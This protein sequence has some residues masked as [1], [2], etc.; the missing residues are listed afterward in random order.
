MIRL[1]LVRHGT[2]ELNKTGV[3]YGSTDC[4]LSEE[5][6][7]ESKKVGNALIEKKIDNIIASDL[8]RTIET[9]SIIK[10]IIC[11]EKV[12]LEIIKN[13]NL[14]ELDFGKWENLY[15]KKIKVEYP[16]EWKIFCE[17]WKNSAPPEGESFKTLYNRVTKALEEILL[18]Y[19]NKDIL[20]VAHQGVLRIILSKLLCGSEE[21]Y[22]NFTFSH[23][24]YSEL[25]IIKGHCN[26]IKINYER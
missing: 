1:Y 6:I 22:W 26:I 16:K 4:P 3:Y 15:Y 5:G 20:I 2:T 18:R 11:R 23:G 10:E 14:R 12:P 13:S 21:L 7:E 8:K 9:A 19:D 17:D 24:C 25:E